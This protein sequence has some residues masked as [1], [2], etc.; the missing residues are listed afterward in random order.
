MSAFYDKADLLATHLRTIAGLDGIVI[1]VDRQKDIVSDLRKIIAKQTGNL[2]LITWTGA[3]NEDKTADGPTFRASYTVTLFSAPLIRAGETPAD[4]I[5]ELIAA[6]LH[7]YRPTGNFHDRIVVDG[8]TPV[9][10]EELPHLIYRIDISTPSQ[11]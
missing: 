7:D 4:D 1:V 10:V 5:V 2:A 9:T 11:L 6:S 8:I 3:P